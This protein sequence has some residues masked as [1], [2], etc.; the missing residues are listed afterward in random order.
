VL[1][2]EE[3]LSDV[4]IGL[5]ILFGLSLDDP[6]L[7]VKRLPIRPRLVLP[8][9]ELSCD[10]LELSDIDEFDIELI[11]LT[12]LNDANVDCVESSVSSKS[13]EDIPNMIIG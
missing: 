5:S 6:E 3:S 11:E 10:E 9:I 2:I 8:A 4:L 1:A 12:E 7:C 13:C